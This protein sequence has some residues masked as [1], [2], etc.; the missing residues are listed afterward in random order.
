MA[1]VQG[2]QEKLSAEFSWIKQVVVVK[3]DR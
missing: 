3:T 2:L 1:L